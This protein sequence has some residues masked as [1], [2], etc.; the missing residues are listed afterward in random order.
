MIEQACSKSDLLNWEEPLAKRLSLAHELQ[1][2]YDEEPLVKDEAEQANDMLVS[3]NLLLVGLTQLKARYF[4]E[5]PVAKLNVLK[6][7]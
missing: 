4:V 3:L 5:I 6:K 7:S 1:V 2:I